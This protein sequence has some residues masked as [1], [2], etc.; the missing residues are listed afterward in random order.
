[1]SC[2]RVDKITDNREN[3]I[4]VDECGNYGWLQVENGKVCQTCFNKYKYEPLEFTSDGRI[5]AIKEE[6][7]LEEVN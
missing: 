5:V 3:C 2:I 6:R 7:A 4:H 1:M